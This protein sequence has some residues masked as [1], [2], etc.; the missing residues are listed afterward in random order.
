MTT[1][2]PDRDDRQPFASSA[3]QPPVGGYGDPGASGAGRPGPGWAGAPS[4]GAW[5]GAPYGA[6]YG[7]P[8]G[9]EV[10]GDQRSMAAVAHGVTLVAAYLSAGWLGFV[11]PLVM[12]F[13]W[14]DS[15]PF[16]RQAA[17]GA[18][19]FN[20]TLWIVNALAWLLFVTIVGIVVAVPLWIVVAVAALVCHVWATVRAL[21]G[22]T[23]HYPL[24]VPILR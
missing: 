16:L 20:V 1:P 14:K 24:Q 15:K 22:R 23:F 13:V 9:G 18:F 8:H 6:P 21:D 11:V 19:N 2:Q 12:W 4:G 5:G 10:P 3:S 7:S 17:A